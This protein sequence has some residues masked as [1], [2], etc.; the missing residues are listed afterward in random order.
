MLFPAYEAPEC[1]KG[2]ELGDEELGKRAEH[3][4]ND[5][6]L[7]KRLVAAFESER[8]DFPASIHVEK[9]IYDAFFDRADVALMDTFHQVPWEKRLAIVERFK[10]SRLRINRK[11]LDLYVER[12]HLLDEAMRDAHDIAG[13]KRLLGT[14]EEVAW[15]TLP[16]SARA[17]NPDEDGCRRRRSG[18]PRRT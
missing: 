7:R 5:D 9:K 4:Q 14:C 15:L 6:P 1:C 18:P 13:A 16:Q 11:A 8:T 3:L 10:D 17:T 2:R 12:P